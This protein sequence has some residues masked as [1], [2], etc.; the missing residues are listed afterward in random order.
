MVSQTKCKLYVKRRWHAR[1]FL[2]FAG[3]IARGK[4]RPRRTTRSSVVQQVWPANGWVQNGPPP[5][6]DEGACPLRPVTEKQ[7][8][9]RPIFNSTLRA[10]VLWANFRVARSTSPNAFGAAL[11]SLLEIRP[12][13]SRPLPS[14]ACCTTLLFR[15]RAA[16][17][18][19]PVEGMEVEFGGQQRDQHP[20]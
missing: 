12:N 1:P 9:R 4:E 3:A 17:S 2:I 10:A 11:R 13:S 15:P 19:P 5:R 6:R 20:A 18:N 16:L 8:R 7:R 14:H